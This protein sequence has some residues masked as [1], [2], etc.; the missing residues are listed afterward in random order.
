MSKWTSFKN[1]GML[2]ENFRKFVSEQTGTPTPIEKLLGTDKYT[3]F[4]DALGS[5]IQNPKV[6]SVIAAGTKDRDGD[7]S[8]DVFGFEDIAIPVKDLNPTQREIDID[9]S[10]AFPYVDNPESFKKQVSSD[11]PHE[12]GSRIITFNGKYIIDGHHRWS[13]LYVCNKNASILATNMT[14]AGL[15]PEDVLQAVQMSIGAAAKKIPIQTVEGS[16]LLEMGKGNITNW[17]KKNV[18]RGFYEAIAAVP[19]IKNLIF[20]FA[21][22]SDQGVQEEVGGMGIA[23]LQAGLIN[24]AWSNIASMRKTSQAVAPKSDRGHMPQTGGVKWKEPLEKGMIDIKPPF[25][26]AA[27]SIKHRGKR[28]KVKRNK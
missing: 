5:N 26:Q 18:G 24:F 21:K 22:Y 20:K 14:I 7:A 2:F 8:D 15:T 1:Q 27:E 6:Q 12:V 4:V 3:A 17:I 11:G 23:M 9:K 19:E 13:G 16:N 25:A 10:M 28:I